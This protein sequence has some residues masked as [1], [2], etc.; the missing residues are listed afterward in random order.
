MTNKN[1]FP[2]NIMDRPHLKHEVAISS[3]LVGK[4]L[5]LGYLLSV[6]DGEEMAI[7]K[8]RDR[9]AITA[10][11][12]ATDQTNLMIHK[13]DGEYIGHIMLIHGNDLDLISDYGA[14]AGNLDVMEEIA[15]AADT[16]INAHY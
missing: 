5:S 7:E 3:R 16:Y 15:N 9:S 8:S 1:N 14:K 2:A 13:A 10:E 11:F 12:F 6:D 4:A